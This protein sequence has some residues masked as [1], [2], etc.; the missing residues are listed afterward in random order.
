M[1][2]N[3]LISSYGYPALFAGVLLEGEAV[4]I[5]AG[6]LAYNGHLKLPLVM[7]VAFA[8]AFA[9]DEFFFQVGKR[10]GQGFIKNRPPWN[11]RVERVRRFLVRYQI[12]A[13]IGYRFIY[14]MRTVTPVIIGASG[15]DTHRFILLNLCSTILWAVVVASLGFFFGSIIE[16]F[17]RDL[18]RFE[19]PALV[20]IICLA[21]GIWFF[22]YRLRKR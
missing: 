10:K 14:G 1:D 13:I 3:S 4:V 17:L 8:G 15:F 20:V 9:A 7:L 16:V 6:F 22:R 12:L 21:A 19:L 2:F 11:A 18:H 5:M